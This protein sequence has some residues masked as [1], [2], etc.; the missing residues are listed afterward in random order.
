MPNPVVISDPPR[1]HAHGVKARVQHEDGKNLF[2][3][4]A[5]EHTNPSTLYRHLDFSVVTPPYIHTL[6]S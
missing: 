5:R 3:I 4:A 1:A 2:G 6:Q